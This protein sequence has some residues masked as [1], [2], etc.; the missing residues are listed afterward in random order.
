MGF[1]NHTSNYELG[2][3]VGT[4]IPSY[5]TDWNDTMSQ[6]DT[7]I[8]NTADSASGLSSRLSAVEAQQTLDV[9]DIAQAK[10]DIMTNATAITT[11]AGD[12][13]AADTALGVRVGANESAI[14]ALQGDVTTLNTNVSAVKTTVET[15]G[16]GLLK[17]GTTS[18]NEILAIPFGT[19]GSNCTYQAASTGSFVVGEATDKV[20]FH[21]CNSDL[22]PI[23]LTDDNGRIRFKMRARV[24]LYGTDASDVAKNLV[25]SVTADTPANA[26]YSQINY[27]MPAATLES[28]KSIIHDIIQAGTIEF[29][30]KSLDLTDKT[31]TVSSMAKIAPSQTPLIVTGAVIGYE[32]PNNFASS[33]NM[34]IIESL[35]EIPGAGYVIYIMSVNQEYDI[36]GYID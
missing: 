4:D 20:K 30:G 7:A 13:A 17:K 9:A 18:A 27:A 22:M 11:E 1:T 3:Y 28:A 24:R 6:I 2:Q 31:I 33:G 23:I 15:Y 10:S 14:T 34:Q 16:A 36:T 12:R 35:Y 32:L 26:V 29:N 21:F 19:F 5:L 8:K 25:F